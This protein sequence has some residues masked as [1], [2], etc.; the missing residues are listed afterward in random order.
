MRGCQQVVGIVAAHVEGRLNGFQPEVVEDASGHADLLV[1]DTGQ[2][3]IALPMI[4]SGMDYPDFPVPLGIFREIE[5]PS[6][7]DLVASQVD[8]ARAQRE[9]DLASLI[10]G[11]ETWEVE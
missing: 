1:H 11:T 8:Q 2:E 10:A 4:M 5:R 3:S 6:Y 9:P 7:D